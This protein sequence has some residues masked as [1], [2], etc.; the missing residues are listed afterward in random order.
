MP[1]PIWQGKWCYTILQLKKLRHGGAKWLVQGHKAPQDSNP[2]LSCSKSCVLPIIPCRHRGQR[3]H[4]SSSPGERRSTR[5]LPYF[6]VRG[7]RVS[8]VPTESQPSP[9]LSPRS[10]ALCCR[11]RWVVN[12]I[13]SF[14]LSWEDELKVAKLPSR[15][16]GGRL[17]CLC[18][19]NLSRTVVWKDESFRVVGSEWE[20]QLCLLP[21]CD[22]NCLAFSFLSSK[23]WV[24]KLS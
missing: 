6:S 17:Q 2:H 4:L 13:N 21:L 20:A 8:V 10:P 14:L 7:V 18:L 1:K 9:A 3:T 11:S 12:L 5:W 15:V 24:R 23:M 16:A 22:C 19:R